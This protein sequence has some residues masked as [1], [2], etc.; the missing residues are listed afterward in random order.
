MALIPLGSHGTLVAGL[1]A[2]RRV[3]DGLRAFLGLLGTQLGGALTV[4]RAVQEEQ[5]R[6]DELQ[7]LDRVKSAFFANVSHELRTPVTLMLGPLAD[8]LGDVHEP[9]P[10]AQHARI[11]TAHRNAGRLIGLVDDV[12]DFTRDGETARRPR[13]VRVDVGA[14]TADLAGA[15]G[16]A[17]EQAGITLHVDCPEPATPTW[18]D[19]HLWERIV[20]NLVGNALKFTPSGTI[21][22]RLRGEGESLTLEVQD[23]G[24]GIPP[25]EHE[26]IFERFHQVPNP[27]ARTSEG[28]GIGLSLVRRLVELQGA[29]SPS[30]APSGRGARSPCASRAAPRTARSRA[31]RTPPRWSTGRRSPRS[32]RSAG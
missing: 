19:P 4:A 16:P 28:A 11:S 5:A 32:T 2:T 1:S 13:R 31:G 3:D 14:R 22:V 6:V 15:F 8:A 30:A 9:L 23:T 24:T 20:L 7:E 29:R 25:E 18:I 21:G 17:A 10:P 27:S 26:R 12:L